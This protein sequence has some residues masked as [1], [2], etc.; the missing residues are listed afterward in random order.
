MK[1]AQV[2]FAPWDKVYSFDQNDL[3]LTEGDMV[4]VKTDLGLEMGKVVGFVEMEEKDLADNGERKVDNGAEKEATGEEAKTPAKE[5]KIKPIIR[6]ATSIDLEKRVSPEEK[7]EALGYCRK[8]VEKNQLEMKLVDVYFSFDGSKITFAFIADGRVDFR[9]LVKDLT[10][11]FSRTVRLYQ[12]GI[13]DEAKIKGDYGPCGRPLCCKKF[14]G[15]LA[16]ITSEMAE[17][18]QVVHRGSERISGM[19][20]RLM[21]CLAFEEKGYEELAKN[22]P[23]LGTKVNVDGKRGKVIGHHILKQSVDVQFPGEKGEDGV[24]A[25]VDLNRNKRK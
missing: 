13:R 17:V 25:E 16:S 7:E 1:V 5:K 4:V 20:G 14:L 21:C 19:C 22:M 12:I 11:H 9:E 23:P 10:R 24:I 6:K 2:Q 8:M 15:D 3:A 18:Q